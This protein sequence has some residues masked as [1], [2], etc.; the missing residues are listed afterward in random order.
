MLDRG[1]TRNQA[2]KVATPVVPTKLQ[3]AAAI[4]NTHNQIIGQR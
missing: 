1:T 3:Q 4:A 2:A